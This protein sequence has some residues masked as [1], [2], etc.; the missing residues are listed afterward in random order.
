MTESFITERLRQ[1]FEGHETF[2]KKELSDFYS[3][4][5][6]KLN[7]NTFAWRIYNLKAKKI[8]RAV[9]KTEFSLSYKPVYKPDLDK[10]LKDIYMLVDREFPEVKKSIWSTRWV[11]DFMLHIPG[12][13]WTILEVEKES[14]ET[15]FSFLK[16]N[17][18]KEVFLQPKT[19][20]IDWY[21]A[22]SA[23]PIIVKSLVSLAPLQKNKKIS[24]PTL[25]KILLD[26]FVESELYNVFQGRELGVIFNNA[27]NK[28][29]LNF[30]KLL[31]YAKRRGKEE[32]LIEFMSNKT[33]I[34][35]NFS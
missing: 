27:Y 17:K 32:E 8:I 11:A 34:P 1:H 13:Y 16:E 4:L 10:K 14:V 24:V 3:L 30:S 29:Q 23:Q 35:R 19:K 28:Y 6:P 9:S 26:I 25:E 18:Y 31:A 12:R 2:T 7:E 22:E 20:E 15:V 21:I 5:E 33:D